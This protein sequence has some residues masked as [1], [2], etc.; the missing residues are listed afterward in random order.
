MQ[1]LVEASQAPNFPARPVLIV[2]NRPGAPGLEIAA[3]HG[4]PQATVDHTQ[5]GRDREAFERALSEVLET[6]DVEMVALAGFMRILSPWF[7]RKWGDR[8]INIHPSLLPKYPGLNTH[9]RA[10]EAGDT[11]AGCSV[12]WVSE[13]VDTGEIIAQADIPIEAGD[14]PTTLAQ[15][16]LVCE[17]ELYPKALILAARQIRN[18]RDIACTS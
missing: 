3:R 13:G 9:A 1:A 16:V 17:H 6:A 7:I 14:T 10:I 12:H 4:L 15:K 11:I 18:K 8:M 2:S 5:Y